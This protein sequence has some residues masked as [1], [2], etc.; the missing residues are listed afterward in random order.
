MKLPNGFGSVYKLS[1]NRRNPWCARKTTGW[2]L[3]TEKQKSYPVYQFIG[4]FPTRKEALTA[5]VEYN[6]DPHDPHHDTITFSEI[7]ERWSEEHFPKVSRSSIIGFRSCYSWCT[8]L[9]NMP[10]KDIK[11]DHL[12]QLVNHSGKNEPMLKRLRVLLSMMFN[13]AAMHEIIPRERKDIISYLDIKKGN[14]DNRP[15]RLFTS[16]EVKRLWENDN[17]I[18]LI[19]IYTGLRINEL[20]NLKTEDVHLKE[21]WFYV[22]KSKTAAGIREVPIA[23]RLVPIFEYF[24]Q[25]G[26]EYLISNNG[27]H[28]TYQVYIKNYWKPV[29]GDAHTPHDCRHT[30]VSMLTVAGIDDRI[31]KKIIG[32]AGNNV[33]E[34]VY[35]HVELPVKLQAVNKIAAE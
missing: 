8:E 11:L 31:I 21:Q 29:F 6:K 20:L 33:T 35:T 2:T 23:D 5:L 9:Y 26:N 3:D 10:M 27:K 13:Y 22:R 16:A 25:F 17:K 7:Y 15:H 18:A 1:G 30:T 34:A 24:L 12:Q 4:Y 28:M 32:H 19:L 14:P